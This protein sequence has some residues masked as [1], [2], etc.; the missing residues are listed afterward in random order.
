[1]FRP[2]V[3][4]DYLHSYLR[5]HVLSSLDKREVSITQ[6]RG[7]TA[8]SKETEEDFSLTDADNKLDE[9]QREEAMEHWK[10]E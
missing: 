3:D 5:H 6:V 9:W 4:A 2:S 1:M 7:G 8:W 10:R